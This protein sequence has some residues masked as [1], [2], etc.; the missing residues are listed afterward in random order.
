MNWK[1]IHKFNSFESTPPPGWNHRWM[2]RG[3][4]ACCRHSVVRGGPTEY[5][6]HHFSSHHQ[7]LWLT[8]HIHITVSKL[9][10]EKPRF[11]S[12]VKPQKHQGLCLTYLFIIKLWFESLIFLEWPK[13]IQYVVVVN[14]LLFDFCEV[15]SSN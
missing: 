3:G 9:S 2:V 13:F 8:H 11:L 14:F 5:F 6:T 15:V 4:E 1:V 10:A 12:V 7:T